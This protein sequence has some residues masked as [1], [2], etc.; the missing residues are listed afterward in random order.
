MSWFENVA[1]TRIVLP[2]LLTAASGATV[3]DVVDMN[4]VAEVEAEVETEVETEA[5]AEV[6]SA[7]A[8]TP[9]LELTIHTG[10]KSDQI[11]F[12]NKKYHTL[13]QGRPRF[14]LWV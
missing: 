10:I 9:L 3:M 5:G 2:A 6:E 1:R 14:P 11:K 4:V 7:N 12:N 8:S 13:A